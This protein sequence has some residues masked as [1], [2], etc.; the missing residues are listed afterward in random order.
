MLGTSVGELG[1][2]DGLSGFADGL[3]GAVV[4]NL[5]GDLGCGE[6]LGWLVG[7]IV[8][9]G[10]RWWGDELDPDPSCSPICGV[11]VGGGELLNN[12][13]LAATS[14]ERG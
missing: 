13:R 9:C 6:G 7:F 4:G 14:T 12:K 5:V 1:F 2:D 8:G 10:N 3:S 11:R